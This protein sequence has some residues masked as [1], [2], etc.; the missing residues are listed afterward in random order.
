MTS[1]R[2]INVLL[3]L[4]LALLMAVPAIAQTTG[5]ITG[6]VTTE[7]TPLP[8]VT[9]T[10]TSPALQG[11]RTAVTDNNGNY[12]LGALPPGNY[13]VTF[14]LEGL[15][16]VTRTVTV[17]LAGTARADAAMNVSAVEEAI[18]VTASAPAVIETRRQ[19]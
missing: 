8:G 10:I 7:G 2:S 5:N 15:Q 14:D 6:T 18:T 12:T 4:T 9:I 11:T 3:T 17:N 19:C 1:I 16:R 13:L